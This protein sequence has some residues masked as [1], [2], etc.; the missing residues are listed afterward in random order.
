[1]AR[2]NREQS[3]KERLEKLV[4]ELKSENRQLK[5]RLGRLTKGYRK[6]LDKDVEESE[7]PLVKEEVKICYECSHGIMKLVIVAN[8]RWRQCDQCLNRTKAKIVGI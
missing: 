7:E 6:Y 5:K 4:R 1:M 3:D 2:K 8:R